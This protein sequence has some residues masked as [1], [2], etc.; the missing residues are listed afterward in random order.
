VRWLC[1]YIDNSQNLLEFH[2]LYRYSL[3]VHRVLHIQ[4]WVTTAF[5]NTQTIH[6]LSSCSQYFL[7]SPNTPSHPKF[8]G[9]T[10]IHLYSTFMTSLRY[11]EW[12]NIAHAFGNILS[13]VVSFLW[14]PFTL[15][16]NS[17]GC[18]PLLA[19]YIMVMLVSLLMDLLKNMQVESNF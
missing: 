1:F 6:L 14:G 2:Q 13:L 19:S 11:Q 16:N 4:P 15:S 9:K 3:Y 12:I 10:I 5:I 17:C 18:V 7:M 8:P